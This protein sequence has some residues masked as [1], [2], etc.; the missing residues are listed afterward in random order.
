MNLALMHRAYERGYKRYIEPGPRRYWG[1]GDERTHAK[2][3]SNQAQ[4]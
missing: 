2:F 1:P 4:N 3:F